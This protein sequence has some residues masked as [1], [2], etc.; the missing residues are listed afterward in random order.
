AGGFNYQTPAGQRPTLNSFF[1][2]LAGR[3]NISGTNL[4]VLIPFYLVSSN[5]PGAHKRVL[6][7][8]N[9]RLDLGMDFNDLDEQ[10]KTQNQKIARLRD[11]LPEINELINR[12]EQ[13]LRLSGEEHQQL[14]QEIE[15]YLREH[16]D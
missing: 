7:F 4:M 5:D 2:W 6:Q 13:N 12:L 11:T 8:F 10:I 3:R 9:Q 1:L 14:L 16:R 15:K